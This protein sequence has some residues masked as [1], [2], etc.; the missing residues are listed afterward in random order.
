[1]KKSPI[2]LAALL[3]AIGSASVAS[4]STAYAQEKKDPAKQE[5][6]RQEWSKPY[7]EIQTLIGNKQFADAMVKIEALN[8]FENKTPYEKFFLSR[9]KAVV[10]SSTGDNNLLAKCFEEMIN[11]DFLTT[12]EK[13]KYLEAMAGI[14]F[15]EKKY[16]ESQAWTLKALAQDKDNTLLQDLLVRNY[17]LQDDY[18]NTVA[19]VKKQIDA[20]IAAKRVPTVDRLRLLHGG[21]AKMKNNEGV[22][23]A[24]EL[25]V[26]YHPSREYWADLLY[27]LPNNK[28]FSDRLR[29]DWY[30][31]LMKT[32]NLEDDTQF[33]EM[34]EIA[35]LAGLPL[36]AKEA[37][38]YG[39]KNGILGK[40]KNASKHKP[41]LDK[42][43]KQA[44][45]DAKSLDA[46]ET[47]ARAGKNGLGMVNM[48][49]NFV[50]H[51][52]FERGIALI[53]AGMA[54]GGLKAPEEAKLHLGMA[55]LA[56]GNR[57]KGEEVLKTVTGAD[58]SSD[59]ARYWILFKQ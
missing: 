47:A 10:A 45:D 50:I 58:G 4:L 54:K 35:L 57:A 16:V 11:S 32:G 43:T 38:E 48:G 30:R 56:A 51:G 19:E 23:A 49:Y 6:I 12:A 40:G 33:M 41:L 18:V 31:L 44:A 27:R 15:N 9:T 46:G 8:A 20:D 21:H 59:L 52:Q 1:M 53:E 2:A 25:L 26:T 39:F 17:Y 29:L 34:A 22:T 55:Y 37:L 3:L 7:T 42:A 28:G 24:L 13:S 36:E 5:V 14:F